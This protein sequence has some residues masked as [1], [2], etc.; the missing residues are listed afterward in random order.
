MT[1]GKETSIE[2]LE[3]FDFKN[4]DWDKYEQECSEAVE[5]WL[6]GRRYD[7]NIDNDYDSCV[8]QA[9]RK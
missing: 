6:E 5:E 2:V 9:G 8:A 3:K 4:T 7:G 1:S